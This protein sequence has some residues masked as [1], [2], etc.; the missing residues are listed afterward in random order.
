MWTVQRSAQTGWALPVTSRMLMP[1]TRA[2]FC[3][4]SMRLTSH[5]GSGPL[6]LRLCPPTLERCWPWG[7]QREPLGRRLVCRYGSMGS[8]RCRPCRKAQLDPDLCSPGGCSFG[9]GGGLC[10]SESWM[11]THCSTGRPGLSWGPPSLCRW[12]LGSRTPGS[13]GRTWAGAIFSWVTA[14]GCFQNGILCSV[15]RASSPFL[16]LEEGGPR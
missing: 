4:D 2:P 3:P 1:G 13:L 5:V 15:P 12:G 11:G 10:V 6:V 8:P 9:V 14:S 7:G 16:F